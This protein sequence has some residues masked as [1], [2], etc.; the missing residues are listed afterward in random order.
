MM[1]V[2]SI[3]VESLIATVKCTIITGLEFMN[4][5]QAD[6]S[7]VD[8]VPSLLQCLAMLIPE[9]KLGCNTEQG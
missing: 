1:V 9:R 6:I 4:I 7:T 8:Q 2:E 5:V 3:V